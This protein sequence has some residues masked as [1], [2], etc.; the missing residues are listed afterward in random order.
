MRSRAQPICWPITGISVLVH[1][2]LYCMCRYENLFFFFFLQ[3][4]MQKKL[5][6]I[7]YNY[8][9]PSEVSSFSALMSFYNK[10][11]C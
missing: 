4:I 5:L 8:D 11:Y 9:I 10:V 3:N 7:I 6:G 1:V 2:V